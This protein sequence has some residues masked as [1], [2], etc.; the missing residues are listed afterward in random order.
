MTWQITILLQI[1]TSAFLTIFTRTL[2]LSVR[3]VFFGVGLI[4]YATIALAGL[5]YCV[6]HIGTLPK[7][8]GG[9]VW[10]YLLIEGLFIPASWLVQY[11]IITH[12]GAANAVIV[13]S[14]NMITSTLVGILFFRET[15]SIS[16]L[17]GAVL[18][19]TGILISLKIKPDIEHSSKMSAPAKAGLII[20]CSILFAIGMFGEKMAINQLGPWHYM[21]YGWLMQFVG[22]LALFLLFGRSEMKHMNIVIAKKAT[23]LGAITS[24]AGLLYVYALSKGSLSYTVVAISG[25]SALVLVLAA[26]FLKERNQMQ[27]RILAFITVVVGLVL[28]LHS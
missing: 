16:F 3:R 10:F 25:K 7:L 5:M 12:L 15:L 6:M 28:I 14:A 2:T 13:L 26:I 9:A 11:K 19:L 18:I 8:P 24:V 23:L 22:V 21:A 20:V 27:F 4:S 17:V 1:I